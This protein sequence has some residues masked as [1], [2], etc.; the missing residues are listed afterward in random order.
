[1]T[2]QVLQA[3]VDAPSLDAAIAL[4]NRNQV[5]SAQTS[6]MAEALSAFREKRAPRFTGK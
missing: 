3:N 6:D 1:M 4:E 5:L 2:K